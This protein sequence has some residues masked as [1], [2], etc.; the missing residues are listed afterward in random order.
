M[1]QSHRA[2]T[3]STALLL[4]KAKVDAAT[5]ALVERKDAKAFGNDDE[6]R[7]RALRSGEATNNS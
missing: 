2:R 5:G 3:E 4:A 6:R 7:A 1:T